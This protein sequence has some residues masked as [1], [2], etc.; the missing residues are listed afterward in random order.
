[1][2]RLLIVLVILS[3]LSSVSFANDYVI[4]TA[5]RKA[6]L[7]YISKKPYVEVYQAVDM[8]LKLKEVKKEK[9]VKD[10]TKATNTD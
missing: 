3:S 4:N 2:R 5:Q 9:V 8:L 7:D 10:D 1:M 6:L